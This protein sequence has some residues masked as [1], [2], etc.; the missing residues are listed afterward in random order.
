LNLSSSGRQITFMGYSAPADGIDISNSNTP[1]AP[2][3]TNP[4]PSSYYRAVASVNASGRLSYTETN[5][6]SGNNGRA[7]IANDSNGHA[8]IYTAGNAGSG[9]NPQPAGVVL[10]AGAQIMSQRLV[11]AFQEPGHPDAGWQLQRRA[12]GRQP[13]QDWQGRQLPR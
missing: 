4:V 13:R 5:A 6:Y 3:P 10:G 11:A 8:L 12:T 7:A 2:D 1:L 9:S